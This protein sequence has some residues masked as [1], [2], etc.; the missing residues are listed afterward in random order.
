MKLEYT[1]ENWECWIVECFSNSP[2]IK[3]LEEPIS[4]T[5]K[6]S[7]IYPRKIHKDINH[8][9]VRVKKVLILIIWNFNQKPNIWIKNKAFKIIDR[10]NF[11]EFQPK[12]SQIWNRLELKNYYTRQFLQRETFR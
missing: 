1:N 9:A 2:L 11:A 8:N 12:S 7:D 6:Y 10:Q 4:K 5:G 3:Q